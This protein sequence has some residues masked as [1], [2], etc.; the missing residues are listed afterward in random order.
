LTIHTSLLYAIDSDYLDIVQLLVKRG[1]PL[2]VVS[3]ETPLTKAIMRGHLNIARILIKSGAD[4]N[5]G[6]ECGKVF[7]EV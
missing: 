7:V 3:P 4:V 1:A 6:D 5:L 2:N